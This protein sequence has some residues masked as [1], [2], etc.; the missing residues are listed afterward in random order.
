MKKFVSMVLAM[1]VLLCGVYIPVAAESGSVI[2][3]AQSFTQFTNNTI[4]SDV[5]FSKFDKNTVYTYATVDTVDSRFTSDAEASLIT[6][7]G[8]SMTVKRDVEKTNK[9]KADVYVRGTNAKAVNS[10]VNPIEMKVKVKKE[11]CKDSTGADTTGD[12][13]YREIR[14]TGLTA[15]GEFASLPVLRLK[16]NGNLT[17]I[18]GWIDYGNNNQT[19]A[20]DSD[21]YYSFR[22]TLEPTT[23]ACNSTYNYRLKS[24]VYDENNN[25]AVVETRRFVS[26]ADAPNITKNHS[27]TD[28]Y[29]ADGFGAVVIQY[30]ADRTAKRVSA[31]TFKDLE[32][33]KQSL[34]IVA[35]ANTEI[36]TLTDEVAVKFNRDV[37][38]D[39]IGGITMTDSSNN[40]VSGTPEAGSD[41]ATVVLPLNGLSEGTYTLN[42]PN[43]VSDT[44]GNVLV[45]EYKIPYTASKAKNVLFSFD[46]NDY[47][48]GSYSNT[49]FAA[50]SGLKT[51]TTYKAHYNVE[52]DALQG[53]NVLSIMSGTDS[54]EYLANYRGG[55]IQKGLDTKVRKGR[56]VVETRAKI[57][58]S[59]GNMTR[60]MPYAGENK[61]FLKYLSTWS[62]P[63]G[64]IRNYNIASDGFSY[65]H[66][67][68]V[69]T[70]ATES[71]PWTVEGYDLESD[72]TSPVYTAELGSDVT[73]KDV[74][75][76]R[77]FGNQGKTECVNMGIS[78]A[79]TSIYKTEIP[80]V[81]S[82]VYD[83]S[84]RK[85]RIK[86]STAFENL[87]DAEAVVKDAAGRT[88][89]SELQSS[90]TSDEIV[91]N[92]PYGL[93]IGSQYT[94]S[95]SKLKNPNV[96]LRTSINADFTGSAEDVSVYDLS[97]SI[98]ESSALQVSLGVT[99]NTSSEKEVMIFLPSYNADGSLYDVDCEK[100][101]VSA[102]SE[103]GVVSLKTA[104]EGTDNSRIIITN[105]DISPYTD[106]YTI[107]TSDFTDVIR[108]IADMATGAWYS[109]DA[110]VNS[111]AG[112]DSVTAK[113]EYKSKSDNARSVEL[114][115][116]KN[117]DVIKSE[118]VNVSSY[119]TLNKEY[120]VDT[121]GFVSGDELQMTV[122]CGSKIL[123]D[124]KL[125]YDDPSKVVDVLL[126]A[127]QS[128]AAGAEANADES[129]KPEL[130]TVHWMT[131]GNTRLSTEGEMGFEAALGK[132]W[133]EETGHTV[134]IVQTAKG[135]TGFY[136]NIW[137]VGDSGYTN[138]STAYRAALASVASDS[139]YTL[140]NRYV[141][142][143]QGELEESKNWT[144]DEYNAPFT[145][146]VDGMMSESF[147]GDSSKNIEKF[148]VLAVR[149]SSQ[150]Y[151]NN[152]KITGPRASQYKLANTDDRVVIVSNIT[153]NWY[154]DESVRTWFADKYADSVYHSGKLPT[155]INE[156]IPPIHYKQKGYNE[157]GISAAEGMYHYI[158]GDVT[159]K[160]VSVLGE[161]GRI[162]VANG[163]SYNMTTIDLPV[164]L[165]ADASYA[166][167]KKI[168]YTSS[169][170]DVVT[171][172]SYGVID[173]VAVGSSVITVTFGDGFAL[174]FTINVAK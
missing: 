133:N 27:G 123:L 79:E 112:L 135:G 127:G 99:N 165:S 26:S 150:Y 166:S 97:K 43:T 62:T 90:G 142:W 119:M 30:S 12:T 77:M 37:D 148:G 48:A 69:F 138:A 172:D 111:F 107:K 14:I 6:T 53:R 20:V 13:G 42:I 41:A 46:P 87:E 5:S 104:I 22:I 131:M 29:Y 153:E 24:V 8:T 73:L 167:N 158:Q 121:T 154:S 169:N 118:T 15:D 143:L 105:N 151:P 70:R 92:M 159:A 31:V 65:H 136:D 25:G 49:E 95:V 160:A 47:E 93:T 21:G 126:I 171:I 23:E 1:S 89:V 7:D 82:A 125:T 152:L 74:M 40:V 98:V 36:G 81:V 32:M 122:K 162:V 173:A 44:D 101:T 132:T 139:G 146:M 16:S 120:N 39:T 50:L 84:S 100:F 3:D 11:A 33:Y 34:D 130:G 83:S 102:G 17:R 174:S 134:L 114:S 137:N 124:R 35:P 129:L 19:A 76:T 10:N 140:G 161:K 63:T 145:A 68:F 57:I 71:D 103:S 96:N 18:T 75:L 94:A 78:L 52:Y 64:V 60:W 38:A 55:Y 115:V 80:S 163:G 109:G 164:I 141:F 91:L 86:L 108:I 59:N 155:T 58:G 168:A 113:I 128:N 106:D 88:V 2:V 66:L 56:L 156:V 110:K 157:L 116:L 51:D 28:L 9:D 117:G 4:L 170:T 72:D 149:D 147:S 61:G 144:A 54:D 85:L 67:A 45:R